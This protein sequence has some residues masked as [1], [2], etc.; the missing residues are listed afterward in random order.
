VTVSRRFAIVGVSVLIS[1]L[2][3]CGGRPQGDPEPPTPPTV[4]VRLGVVARSAD[5]VPASVPAVIAARQKATLASRIPATVVALPFREGDRVSRGAVVLRLD[6]AALQ[7]AEGAAETAVRAAERDLARLTVL[8]AEQ[9]A[10]PRDHD[11]AMARAAAARATLQGVRD[12]LSYAV[13]RAPFAGVVTARPVNVGDIVSPGTPLLD[14]EGDGGLEVRASIDAAL[15]PRPTAGQRFTVEVDGQPAPVPATVR[16]ISPAADPTTHRFDIRADL[17][18][19]PGLRSGLFARMQIPR[20]DSPSRLVVPTLAVVRR[21]GLTGI[22]VVS[23]GSA[24]LRWVAVGDDQE[25]VTELRAG[26][27]A[28]DRVVLD[29][30]KVVDGARVEPAP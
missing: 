7:S 1:G 6:A 27:E 26:A 4:I 10:A 25:G 5:D 18:S 24:R 28:G 9:V 2:V 23:E 3:S 15:A 17:P 12:S 29:P 14:I 22:F 8:L 11:E 20:N 16:S 19:R 30:D 21:G 13:L